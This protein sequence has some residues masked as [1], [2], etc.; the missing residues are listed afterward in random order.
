MLSHRVVDVLAGPLLEDG[1]QRVEIPVV[2]EVVRAR[3]LRAAGGSA[4]LILP[5]LRRRETLVSPVAW[6]PP[7]LPSIM[8]A[9]RLASFPSSAQDYHGKKPP[10][11]GTHL[12]LSSKKYW[13]APRH[14]DS[15]ALLLSG[16]FSFYAFRRPYYVLSG[17]TVSG[18]LPK[19]S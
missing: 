6:T 9:A 14:R 19:S 11:A 18:T 10:R 4:G 7:G 2:I 5:P 13:I 1:A 16:T 12:P 8:P 15:N 17:K 3:P